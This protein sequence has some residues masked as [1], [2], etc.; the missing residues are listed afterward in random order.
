VQK[1]KFRSDLYFRLRVFPIVIPPL[2]QRKGDIPS[3]TQHFIDKKSQEMGITNP[4]SLANGALDDLMQYDWPGNVRELENAIE[5]ALI[6]RKDR[7]INFKDIINPFFPSIPAK[8]VPHKNQ[9]LSLDQLVTE[10]ITK[11]LTMTGGKVEG[12]NGAATVL[13]VKPNTLRSRMKKMG[14][15]FGR[16]S[17]S[18]V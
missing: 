6:L 17:I 3:L 2:K 1:E 15:P 12:K 9:L 10:E 14:I 5:R 13:G 11:V 7:F 16:H 18:E 8:A 4:I